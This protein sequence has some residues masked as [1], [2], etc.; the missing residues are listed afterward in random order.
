MKSIKRVKKFIGVLM[1]STMMMSA[2]PVQA[3]STVGASAVYQNG[4]AGRMAGAAKV[5]AVDLS[6]LYQLSSVTIQNTRTM[7][8][9]DEA[10]AL[11]EEKGLSV[12]GYLN[13]GV[14]KVSEGNLNVRATADEKGKIVGKLP[15]NA[16]CDVL[17]VDGD[18]VFINSGEVTGYVLGTYLAMDDEAQQLGKEIAKMVA[19]SKTGGLRIRKDA[20]TD[21]GIL[22]VMSEG[23]EVTVLEDLGDWIKVDFDG[24]EA[25]VS[26][27]YV[28]VMLSMPKATTLSELRYGSGVSSTRQQ[29]CDYAL[30]FVGNPYVWGGTSL[31]KGADCSGFTMQ[32]FKQ[33]GVTLPHSSRSQAGYGKKITSSQARPGD[34]FFYGSN[35]VI[36][37]VAIYIGGGQIVHAAN[38]REGIKVSKC[39]Y[40]N[41]MAVRS[42]LD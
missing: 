41:V 17:A 11:V 27:E 37:H 20:S 14:C 19:K 22:D 34:L 36:G 10:V 42:I 40:R 9:Y 5:G 13:L 39:N 23:E 35:G 1:A 6:S 2:F 26:A 30:Q 31:T 15:K 8:G 3:S 33:Y 12:L 21:S 7:L 18:W 25:Y 32:I 28:D 4:A 16:G 24:D 38:S 29:L